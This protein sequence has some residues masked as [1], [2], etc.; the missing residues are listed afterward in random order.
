MSGESFLHRPERECMAL[1]FDDVRHYTGG[2]VK[3]YDQLIRA[4][5]GIVK[6]G[7]S[8]DRLMLPF[9]PDPCFIV[10]CDDEAGTR[11]KYYVLDAHGYESDD[12]PLT[13]I[14]DKLLIRSDG[15][16]VR[17]WSQT[18]GKKEQPK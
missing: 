3:C 1:F 16:E 6:G 7:R 8:F 18:I 17:L 9:L 14:L 5:Y 10:I 11:A 15:E 12:S 2:T 4:Y 13:T